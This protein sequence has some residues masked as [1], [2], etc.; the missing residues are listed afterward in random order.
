MTSPAQG[1]YRAT[2]N[3]VQVTFASE[4]DYL[5]A[6]RA[7]RDMIE[8]QNIPSLGGM[9]A[10]GG[11]GGGGGGEAGCARGQRRR[12]R[13]RLLNGATSA[14][15][16]KTFEDALPTA[17]MVAPSWT[18]WNV[19]SS[20]RPDPGAASPVPGRARRDRG[21]RVGAGRPAHRC[22]HPDGQRRRQGRR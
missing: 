4:A 2:I 15:S 3:G 6:D 19:P 20:S 1:G 17:G 16:S 10:V 18:P 21:Q 9:P 5:K 22:G 13:R 8:S 14:A 7:L 11:G 12:Y